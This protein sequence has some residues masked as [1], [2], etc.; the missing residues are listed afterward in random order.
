MRRGLI[1]ATAAA[2]GVAALWWGF[3][4][5]DEAAQVWLLHSGINNAEMFVQRGAGARPK[6]ARSTA[7]K[8]L[9]GDR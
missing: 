9:T 7:K 5:Y 6:Q 1:G 2:A 3:P 4:R 8:E